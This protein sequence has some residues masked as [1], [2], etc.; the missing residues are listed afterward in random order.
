MK[1]L[2]DHPRRLIRVLIDQ[3]II[4]ALH[5]V[6]C[7]KRHE[8]FECIYLVNCNISGRNFVGAVLRILVS[9]NNHVLVFYSLLTP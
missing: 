1:G 9:K 8:M 3:P 7:L 6:S 4:L 2:I 5:Q